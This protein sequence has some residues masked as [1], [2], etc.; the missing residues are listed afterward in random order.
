M[1]VGFIVNAYTCGSWGDKSG[2]CEF[3][4]EINCLEEGRG[5]EEH[6]GENCVNK[7][8]WGGKVMVVGIESKS[9]IVLFFFIPVCFCFQEARAYC[10]CKL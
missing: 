1:H 6:Q 7:R 4:L 2:R 10:W 8:Y 9:K 3:S 5:R